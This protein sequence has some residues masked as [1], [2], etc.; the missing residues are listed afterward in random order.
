MI[1]E[2]RRWGD[3]T[4]VLLKMLKEDFV[5]PICKEEI[6]KELMSRRTKDKYGNKEKSITTV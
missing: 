4:G 3:S 5:H 6:Q 1:M 2:E